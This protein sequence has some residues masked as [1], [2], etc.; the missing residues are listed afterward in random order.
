MNELQP[1][2]RRWPDDPDE[3]L[4]II[5]ELRPLLSASA[6][7][8]RE[9]AVRLLGAWDQGGGRTVRALVLALEDDA[10]PVRRAAAESLGTF[11]S[12]GRALESALLHRLQDD[13]LAV[14]QAA[15]AS[16]AGFG[17]LSAQAL[18]VATRAVEAGLLND[19]RVVACVW[20]SLIA[21]ELSNDEL[22]ALLK[23]EHWALRAAGAYGIWVRR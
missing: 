20:V 22:A 14:R 16:L 12:Y 8:V 9:H 15:L 1:R 5:A 6:P 3:R 21:D 10:W 13:H 2:Y 4:P 11:G 7:E 18:D 23:H 17:P 19:G